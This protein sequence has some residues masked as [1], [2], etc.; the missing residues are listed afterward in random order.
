MKCTHL[1]RQ[2]TVHPYAKYGH[3]RNVSQELVNIYIFTLENQA[4]LEIL[5]WKGSTFNKKHVETLEMP[6]N[7]EDLTAS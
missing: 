3:C 1:K 2:R 4:T 5:T 6:L 7:L